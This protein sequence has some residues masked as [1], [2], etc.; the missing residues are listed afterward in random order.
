MLVPGDGN[1]DSDMAAVIGRAQLAA[2]TATD[3]HVTAGNLAGREF[4]MVNPTGT[5]GYVSGK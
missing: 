4:P 5:A 1:L 3:F 2:H